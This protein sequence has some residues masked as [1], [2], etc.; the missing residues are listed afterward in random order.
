MALSE[1]FDENHRWP[2]LALLGFC[3]F[4]RDARLFLPVIF[5]V[6]ASA[7]IVMFALAV[8]TIVGRTRIFPPGHARA[9]PSFFVGGYGQDDPSSL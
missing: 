3:T 1:S 4:A 8:F 6:L 7:P 2:R 9:L 5:L